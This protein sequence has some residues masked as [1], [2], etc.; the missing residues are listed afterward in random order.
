MSF[1]RLAYDSDAYLAT[2]RQSVG[3]ADYTLHPEYAEHCTPCYDSDPQIRLTSYAGRGTWSQSCTTG[4]CKGRALVDV[5][6]ELLGLDR[7]ATRDP[8]KLYMPDPTY[9]D[10]EDIPACTNKVPTEDTRLS[11]PA[12]TLRGTGWNRWEWLCR[13]PQQA[14]MIPF[15]TLIDNRLLAKDNFR[16]QLPEPLD[17]SMALPP[18][19]DD[20]VQYDPR[21][22]GGGS[23]ANNVPSTHWRSCAEIRRY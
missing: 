18:P 3:A 22:C 19:N 23:L 2:L 20:V 7:K 6:S 10:P 8:T 21:E 4:R 1:T 14:A 5:S 12:S 16:P 9:C 11:N 15:Q 17:Q 13:D